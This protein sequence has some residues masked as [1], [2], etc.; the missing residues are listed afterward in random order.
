MEDIIKAFRNYFNGKVKIPSVLSEQG[1]IDDLNSGWSIRYV[2]LEDE[3]GKKCLDFTA[4]HRMT[5][6]RHHRISSD[7]EITSLE[8]YYEYYSYDPNIP[9]DEAKK[10]KEFFAHNRAVTKMLIK[11]GLLDKN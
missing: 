9:G 8:M 11:K 3:K 10:E 4:E 1:I 7:G 2:L 6:P 5:N